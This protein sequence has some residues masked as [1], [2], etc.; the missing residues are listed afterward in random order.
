M[1]MPQS[2][3]RVCFRAGHEES[4]SELVAGRDFHLDEAA[5]NDYFWASPPTRLVDLLRIA[6]SS[7]VIDRLVRR[8]R[9]LSGKWPRLLTASVEVQEPD[10]WNSVEVRGALTQCLDFVSGDF[11]EWTFMPEKEK[12]SLV[13]RTCLP[14][15]DREHPI[16]YLHSGGMDS[17]AG[18]CGQ[19]REAP[20]RLVLP[21]TIW[22]HARQKKL[23]QRQHDIIKK[24]YGVRIEP[25]IVKT[26]LIWRSKQISEWSQRSRS[27]LFCTVGGIAAAMSGAGTVEVYESG[28]GA[29]N[30]PLMAGMVGSLAT[31]GCHPEF[32]RQM[33]RLLTLVSG[34]SITFRLPFIDRTKGEMVKQM[35]ADG[36]EK[37]A[38]Q[39]ASCVHYPLRKGPPWQCGVCPGCIFRRQAMFVGDIVEPEG[40]YKCDLFGPPVNLRLIPDEDLLYLKAVLMQVVQLEELQSKTELPRR[41]RRHILGTSVLTEGESQLAIIDLLSRYRKEWLA[42]HALQLIQGW[43]LVNRI[44]PM[45][46]EMSHA[47]A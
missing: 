18:I 2:P 13:W 9:G 21:V 15:C 20:G 30:L 25:L 39:T 32:L 22:H 34:Q 27:F 46:K 36:V 26:A 7:Y 8:R 40:T 31:R 45:K 29:I 37:L 16:V 6:M 17:A 43:P 11:W 44:A 12:R 23:I 5:L 3:Y 10:F 38:I 47:S 33:S 19:V 28:V 14:F 42:I 1:K 41:F 35:A 24:R 4:Q